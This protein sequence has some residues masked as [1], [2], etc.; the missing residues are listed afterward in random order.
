MKNIKKY[1]VRPLTIKE[2]M[3]TNGGVLGFLGFLVGFI[4]LAGEMAE[5]FGESVATSNC[6][7]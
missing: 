5:E 6:D 7:Y 1:N 3:E 4:Y 2:S